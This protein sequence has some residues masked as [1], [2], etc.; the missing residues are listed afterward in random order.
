MNLQVFITTSKANVPTTVD[1]A[2][3]INLRG[4]SFAVRAC[5]FP[6]ILATIATAA[7]GGPI[8]RPERGGVNGSR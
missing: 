5:F 7:A 2:D 1:S 3:D 4:A 6:I 8:R